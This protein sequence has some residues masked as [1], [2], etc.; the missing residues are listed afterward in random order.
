M[1]DWLVYAMPLLAVPIVFLYRFVGCGKFLAAPAPE[2]PPAP[3]PG[4][5]P[6]PPPPTPPTEKPKPP[7]YRDYIL[8]LP[9]NPGTVPH[10]EV[11]P[12]GGAVIGYWR[13]VD[14]PGATVAKDE[15]GFQD[16]KYVAG[17]LLPD[18]AGDQSEGATGNFIENQSSLIVTDPAVKGRYFNGGRVEIPFKAGLFTDDFT[19][20]AWVTP[21]WSK[22]SGYEH[23]LFSAA[24]LYVVP[25]ETQASPHGF[26]LA[27][28]QTNTWVV[29]LAPLTTP[30]PLLAP[31]VSMN[32]P[33]HIAMTVEKVGAQ[34]RVRLFVGGAQVSE[35]AVATY[36]PPPGCTL[37]IGVEN[38][39]FNPALAPNPHQPY[40]GIVQEVVLHKKALSA[41]EIENHFAINKNA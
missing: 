11:V 22:I 40:L 4:T 20:E 1:F 38:A 34:R 28:S 24:G 16:G 23:T 30:V 9:G 32:A 5:P 41:A 27:G 7:R 29:G 35:A 37:F 2:E 14:A 26:Q 10:P 8:G 33:T 6:P 15:K 12:D 17:Q 3:P 13:L 19:L 36:S 21:A 25:P 31:L 39:Q 18:N